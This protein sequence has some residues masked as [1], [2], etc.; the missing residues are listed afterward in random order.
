[1]NKLIAVAAAALAFTATA[2]FAQS[3][4]FAAMKGK[5]KP[6]LYDYKMEMEMPGLPAGMGGKPISVQ[7]CVTEEDLEKGAAFN[8][9]GDGKKAPDCDVKDFKMSGNTASY[10]MVCKGANPMEA[11]STIT[12]VPDGYKGTTRM[13][14]D[15]GGQKMNMTSKFEAKYLGPC[16]KK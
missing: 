10:K 9:S 1:M 4:P 2:S 15:H 13:A 5:T 12:F 6:G 7:N 11:D 3:N 14:M 8:R 16:P